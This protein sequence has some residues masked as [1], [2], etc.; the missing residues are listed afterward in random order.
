MRHENFLLHHASVYLFGTVIYRIWKKAR[1]YCA[2]EI[3]TV[4]FYVKKNQNVIWAR[5]F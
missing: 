2:Q 4:L 5:R 3:G 1:M